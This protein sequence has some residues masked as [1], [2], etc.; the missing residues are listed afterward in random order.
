V[1]GG[2]AE[3]R[4]L[5]LEA[6]QAPL[7]P[8]Q[9]FGGGCHG[10]TMRPVVTRGKSGFGGRRRCAAQRRWHRRTGQ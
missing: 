2:A 7:E 5:A 3:V 8:V 1:G 6:P 10:A 9:A 4:E